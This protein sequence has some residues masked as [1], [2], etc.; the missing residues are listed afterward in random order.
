MSDIRGGIVPDR[1]C[2]KCYTYGAITSGVILIQGPPRSGKTSLTKSFMK[3]ALQ[4]DQ[5]L[6]VLSTQPSVTELRSA[7][8]RWSGKL[9]TQAR[10]VDCFQAS[11]TEEGTGFT[12]I[13]LRK[14][15]GLVEKELA[16]PKNGG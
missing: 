12:L 16:G 10:I 7:V 4:K 1:F 11:P 9:G 13:D 14:L 3:I 15:G 6:L 8:D 2:I 5:P